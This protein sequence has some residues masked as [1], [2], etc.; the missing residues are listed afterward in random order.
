MPIQI[1]GNG[2]FRS[3]MITLTLISLSKMAAAEVVGGAVKSF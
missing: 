3:D 1:A 2:C